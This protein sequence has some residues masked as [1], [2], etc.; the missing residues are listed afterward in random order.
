MSEPLDEY[1]LVKRLKEKNSLA[2]KEM[3]SRYIGKLV[4]ICRRYIKGIDDE[5]DVLQNSFVKM[6]SQIEG[7]HYRGNGALYAWMSKIVVNE[8]LQFLRKK[9]LEYD[10]NVVWD[11]VAI[12]ESDNLTNE[13]T[14]AEM[15]KFIQ[16]LP[17]GYRTIFNLYVFEEKTHVEIAEMLGISEGTSASQLFRAKK[18]L[19]AQIKEYQQSKIE[20]S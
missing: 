11:T 3:Y 2:W 6:F 1:H 16:S 20:V 10:D 4:V 7:F 19:A 13:L 12:V 8:S 9:G 14:E 15:I 18:L 5:R 17:D